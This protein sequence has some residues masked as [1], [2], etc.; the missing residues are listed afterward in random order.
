MKMLNA[1][2]T[3]SRR[4]LNAGSIGVN[5]CAELRAGARAAAEASRAPY[6]ERAY[7]AGWRDLSGFAYRFGREPLWAEP[8]AAVL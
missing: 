8:E 2:N 7:A 3:G 6:T 4:L 5:R 1:S